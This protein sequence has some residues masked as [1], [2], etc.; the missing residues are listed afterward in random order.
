MEPVERRRPV[1]TGP[2]ISE[3]D[4]QAQVIDLAKLFGWMHHHDR[5]APDPR[6]QGQWRTVIDGDK[7]Y[8]D[9]TL[10]RAGRVILA[11]LK[12]EKGRVSKEQMAWLLALGY[13]ATLDP[14]DGAPEVY[15]WRPSDRREV[16]ET[17][18]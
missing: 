18:R 16:E 11:E 15:V 6:Q 3:A 5:P 10:A 13:G 12:S 9:L 2:L 14:K 17:L 8:P 4:W 7:G 1:L